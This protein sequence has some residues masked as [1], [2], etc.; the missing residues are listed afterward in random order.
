MVLTLLLNGAK[1]VTDYI[2]ARQRSAGRDT[3][4]NNAGTLVD[5]TV[6]S[7]IDACQR[8]ADT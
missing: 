6:A 4:R 8:G 1:V 5:K 3:C 7:Q 2:D